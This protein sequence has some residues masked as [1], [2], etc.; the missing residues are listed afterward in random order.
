MEKEHIHYEL[1]AGLDPHEVALCAINNANDER[2][3]S[4]GHHYLVVNVKD[5]DGK[6]KSLDLIPKEIAFRKGAM[7]IKGVKDLGGP[8]EM[9]VRIGQI[10]IGDINSSNLVIGCIDIQTERDD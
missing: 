4:R 2:T 3:A 10:S 8:S 1:T 6:K 7:I 9:F 5:D